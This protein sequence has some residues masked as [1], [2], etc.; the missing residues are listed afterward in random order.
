MDHQPFGSII[1][2]IKIYT[3]S[4]SE[5]PLNEICCVEIN[6]DISRIYTCIANKIRIRGIF[7][8]EKIFHSKFV[9][10]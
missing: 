4:Y 2:K 8:D 10:E 9:A 1:P 6:V 7:R 5:I 3:V